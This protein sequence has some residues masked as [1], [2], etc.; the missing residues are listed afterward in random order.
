MRKCFFVK[1]FL[2]ILLLIFS[3]Q[4]WSKADD[5]S[6][7]EIEGM[8]IGDS[9]LDFVKKDYLLA[10]KKDWF[11]SN[12]FSIAADMDLNFLN[13]YDALQIVYRTDDD[14]FRIEGIE[15]IKFYEKNIQQCQSKFNEVFS[16]IKSIFQNVEI[17]KKRTAKHIADKTGKSMVTDQS[18]ITSNDD[19]ITIACYDWSQEIGY[20]DQLRVS[21]RT[22]AY[23][24]FLLKAY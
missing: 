2:S 13:I 24:S 4:S 17:L 14:K 1:I 21:I 16:E 7:F 23:D 22:S 10:H 5:V 19:S 12:E 8:S 15:A 6:E 3:F 20:S 9:A 18:I 11:K